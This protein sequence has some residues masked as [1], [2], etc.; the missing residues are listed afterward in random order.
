MQLSSEQA[1]VE[2]A[3]RY[4]FLFVVLEVHKDSKA[5]AKKSYCIADDLAGDIIIRAAALIECYRE[6]CC[7]LEYNTDNGKD[8]FILPFFVY[9]IPHNAAN[10]HDD[11]ENADII[12]CTEEIYVGLSLCKVKKFLAQNRHSFTLN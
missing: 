11:A 6:F 7:Q 9:G 2:G 4:L 5:N 12:H 3:G 10:C 1:S 8:Y